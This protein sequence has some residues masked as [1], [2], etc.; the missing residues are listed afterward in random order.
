MRS[1]RN[2]NRASDALLWFAA[3]VIA[4]ATVALYAD[5]NLFNSARFADHA[6]VALQEPE[7]R[8][9][10][11]DRLGDFVVNELAEDAVAVRPLIDCSAARCCRRIEQ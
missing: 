2:R 5:A 10:V 6:Q 11:A 8:D 3:L 7:V 9:V 1:R 4:A